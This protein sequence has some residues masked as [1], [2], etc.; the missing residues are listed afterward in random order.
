M[1]PST[2]AAAGPSVDEDIDAL[3]RAIEDPDRR[4]ALLARLRDLQKDTTA[5]AGKAPSD[6]V[7]V[8]V[9]ED[10]ATGLQKR[11]EDLADILTDAIAST[12]QLPALYDWVADQVIDDAQRKIWLGVLGA[13]VL[14]V[15]V[16]LLARSMLLRLRPE[17]DPRHPKATLFGRFAIEIA[18]AIAFAGL[19]LGMLWMAE[20]VAAA[21]A[22]DLESV[23]R[24]ALGL[25]VLLLLAMLWG[26]GIR[27]LFGEDGTGLR[28]TTAG[29]ATAT[30][31]RKGL[32]RLGRLGLLGFGLLHALLI[33]GLPAPI[34]VF[35]L[36]ILYLVTV[37]IAIV[38]IVR[39]REPVAATIRDWNENS[40]SQLAR[41]VPGGFVA[42]FWSYFAIGLVLLHY[43]VW[44][45][46]VPGGLFFLSRATISTFAILVVARLLALGINRLFRAGAATM[47]EGE[48]A[49]PRVQERADRYL[50]PARLLLRGVVSLVALILILAVWNT[51]VV[52]WLASPIGKDFSALVGSLALILAST[53]VAF[54][55]TGYLAERFADARDASGKLRHSNRSRTLASIFK[56]VAFFFFGMA[57]LLT[58]L[59]RLGVEAAPLLAGAGVVGLAIG[60]GSQA[61]VKDLI[62]G[63][64][65][66][67]GDTIRVGD[68]IDIAGKSG[69]VE[70]MSM[71]T[72]TLRAYD[73]NAHTVPYGSI[74]VVTNMTKD[75]S[76]AVIDLD[77]AY[78][79]N[80]DE[81]IR[82]LR[83]IDDRMRKEWPYRRLIM[84]PLDIAGVDTLGDSAVVVRMRS[85]TLPGEQWGIKRE[86][87]RRIKLRFDELGI[88]IPFPH[89][90]VYFG[91][92]K[93][94]RAPP[95]FIER[96][97]RQHAADKAAEP[98]PTGDP[99]DM[100]QAGE[101]AASRRPMSVAGGGTDQLRRGSA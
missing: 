4:S 45:L 89:Q 17:P 99:A 2:A 60:F 41:F 96:L 23:H 30:I 36:H 90:T 9:V 73:G 22:I 92:D 24:A 82:V 64:F 57:G 16:G 11:G 39:L 95:M 50:E 85:K 27:L 66:L 97:H 6:I 8:T 78:R 32:L 44:A 7:A 35:L 63:L 18:G 40:G 10:L 31:C 33:L 84:G 12:D 3:I 61:L 71:R 21:Y 43:L 25:G 94:G 87:L 77:V 47:A 54:E 19:T 69:V 28:L 68:V 72:I 62:T 91:V 20:L 67:L 93:E 76:Y 53:I 34:Y 42:R 26:A 88:S 15:A 56:N 52:S 49:P 55:L 59:S 51:G 81:V 46:K 80:T 75:F 79:E 48:D 29:D 83:E 101:A 38:L 100:P 98:S 37:A 86:F 74:D 70:G 13:I 58:A 1:Q 65:I 14:I 5:P